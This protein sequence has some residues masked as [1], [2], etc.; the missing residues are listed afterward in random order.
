[1]IYEYWFVQFDFPDKSGKPY[2]SSGGKMVW[3]ETLK[4]EIPEG[5]KDIKLKELVQNK[6]IATNPGSH[7]SKFVYTPIDQLPKNKMSFGT[8]LSYRDANSSLQFYNKYDILLGAMRVY[9]HRVCIAPFKGITRTTAMVL[10]PKISDFLPFVYQVINDDK[11]IEYATKISP[12]TQQPYVDWDNKLDSFDT[13][14][15]NNEIIT[16]YSAKTGYIIDSV[17][18]REIENKHLTALRDYLLPLL[19]NGQVSVNYHLSDC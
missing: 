16:D 17:I 8:G 10:T 7:L 9:F 19:M 6:V 2:K 12:G 14:M 1:V 18:E 3:N 15:P 5:W 11:T 4:K 13:I